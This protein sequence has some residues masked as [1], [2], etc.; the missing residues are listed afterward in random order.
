MRLI[1]LL[2][3]I[4]FNLVFYTWCLPQTALGHLVLLFIK[5]TTEEKYK[6]ATIF[7]MDNRFGVSLG[8]FIFL[9]RNY[10]R[11]TI[12]H[13]Y[14]HVIQG[15]IFGPL[16]LIIIGLPSITQNIISIFSQKFGKGIYA[17]NYY[18]RYPENWAD[19]L[20]GVSR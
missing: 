6:Q 10:R 7:W 15:F 11:E 3:K 19:K 8:K 2:K 16:Y 17:R 20:G 4:F 12:K 18:N 1:K 13:E 14:G 5:N 9:G